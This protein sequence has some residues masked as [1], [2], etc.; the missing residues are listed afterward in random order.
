MWVSIGVLASVICVVTLSSMGYQRDTLDPWTFQARLKT[1]GLG[2]HQ[3]VQHPLVGT[4][5]GNNTFSKVYTAEV[6]ADEKKGP[7]EKVLPAL[8]NTF[9][10][11][12]MG[13][14]VPALLC[15]LWIIVRAVQRLLAGVRC[16]PPLTRPIVL[17]IAVALAVIGFIVRNLFDY[18]FAGSLSTLFWIVVA[19]GLSVSNGAR[20]EK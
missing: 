4:G 16:S 5:F 19:T 1:W 3:V 11:V 18:M 9:A 17:R 20:C 15:F 10:M 12:L 7:V 14:G 2:L 13:S 6:Q 8:H